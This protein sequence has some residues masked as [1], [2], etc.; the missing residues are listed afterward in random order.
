MEEYSQPLSTYLPNHPSITGGIVVSAVI[1]HTPPE[2]APPRTL[3]IQRALKDGF[4]LKW[5]TPGGGVEDFDSSII[6]A[7]VREV[8]EETGLAVDA[9]QAILGTVGGFTEWE[10]PKT[11]LRWRKVTFLVRMT[12][13]ELPV[14]QLEAREHRDYKW[15]TEEEVEE[16]GEGK[17]IGFAYGQLRRGILEGFEKVRKSVQEGLER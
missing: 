7:A 11:G 5:E 9:E 17:G 8:K 10:E 4:P 12:G 13:E 14:V 16:E 3:I 1:I 15:V 6:S 2:G